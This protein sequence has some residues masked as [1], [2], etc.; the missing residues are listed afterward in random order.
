MDLSK[1]IFWALVLAVPCG[2]LLRFVSSD[3]T[4]TYLNNGLLAFGG[5]LFISLLKFLIVPVVFFSLLTAAA[6]ME[7]ITSFGRIGI[8]T[9]ALYVTTTMFAICLALIG[10]FL[11]K[12][13]QGIDLVAA[14]QF[15]AKESP[16]LYEVLL[17]IVPSNLLKSMMEVQM[18][19]VIVAAL[20]IGLGVNSCDA[21]TKKR[22]RNYFN[23]FNTLFLRVVDLIMQVAPFGVFCLLTK[24]FSQLGFEAFAPL[25]KYFFLVLFILAAHGIIVYGTIL[26]VFAKVKPIWFL[27]R[28]RV[29]AACAF[30]TSSSS[31][32]LPIT[33]ECV[34]KDMGVDNKVASFT[35][36]LGATINMDGTS[37][38]QGVATVF[39]AQAYGI[40]LSLSD[41]LT[42]ILTATLASIG[43]A[44]VPGVGLITLAMVLK[45]VNLPV[46][47][48]SL[49]IGVDRLLD[50]AR[51]TLNVMGDTIVSCAVARSEGLFKPP[52]PS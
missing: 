21:D 2:L 6:N 52:N 18:L 20:L 43:T 38:M 33:L 10:G 32:T 22:L 40:H 9:F 35:L 1:K 23:D 34:E 39:I 41:A 31:A 44:G 4:N 26:K 49:I 27:K 17:A 15:Q 5:D 47:A 30:S 37:I 50:M 7:S 29:I 13:G 48:I 36:P 45:S 3:F 16:P 14:T 25:L 46:E 24:T 19:P 11:I 28:F 8:K 12:P 42:V 51:T